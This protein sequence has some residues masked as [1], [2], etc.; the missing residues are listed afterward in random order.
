MRTV[1]V[2]GTSEPGVEQQ[3]TLDEALAAGWPP[4]R[5]VGEPLRIRPSCMVGTAKG[6][7][8]CSPTWGGVFMPEEPMTAAGL[9]PII[10]FETRPETSGALK[11]IG[12]P[13]WGAPDAG[14]GIWWMAQVP[15]MRSF[16]TMAG[17]PTADP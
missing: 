17:D 14:L 8:T 13:G 1:V 15:V 3:V 2:V 16:M 11:G 6:S 9:P 7:L 12:G 4:M 10:T 5:T